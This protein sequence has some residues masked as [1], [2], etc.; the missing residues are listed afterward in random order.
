MQKQIMITQD[1]E[2]KN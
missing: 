1:Q 2:N